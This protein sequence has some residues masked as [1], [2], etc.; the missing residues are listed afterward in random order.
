MV[1]KYRPKSPE[2]WLSAAAEM[3]DAFSK[4]YKVLLSKTDRQLSAAFEVGCLH[5]LLNFYKDQGYQLRVDNLNAEGEYRYLTS[6]SG[7]PENFSYIHLSGD[8]GEFEIRQQVRIESHIDPNIAFTPDIVVFARGATIESSKHE[9]Y[10][11]GKRSYYRVSSSWVVAAHEC[12]SMN[13]F[14]ELLVSFLGMFITAHE[15]YP[16]GDAV[17]HTNQNGHMAPTLFVG[18][19][20]RALHWRMIKAL[21][22][23]YKLNIV[24]GLHDG[25]WKLTDAK[26]RLI[27]GA[28]SSRVEEFFGDESMPF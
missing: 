28:P 19:T 1:A 4:E 14:P 16:N 18:G 11:S 21:H 7:N 13:P 12:K 24:C 20:A 6:P 25:T 23:S 22:E 8:D 26:N 5:A 17:T 2:K 15:W 10:A 27:W 3:A 9:D